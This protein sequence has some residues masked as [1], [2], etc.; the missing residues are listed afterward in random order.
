MNAKTKIKITEIG[1]LVENLKLPNTASPK[2]KNLTE[3]SSG[4]GFC[5]RK[6][7]LLNILKRHKEIIALEFRGGYF[8]HTLQ[9]RCGCSYQCSFTFFFYFRG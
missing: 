6:N 5:A 1:F 4:L 8:A 2:H 9:S 7:T 3:G